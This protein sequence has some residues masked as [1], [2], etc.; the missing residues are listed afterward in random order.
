MK[1]FERYIF[2]NLLIAAVFVS[3]TLIVVVFLSQSMQFLEMVL[4]SN[5]SSGSFWLLTFLA[6]PRFFEIIVPLAM[7]AATIFIY[8]RMTMDSELAAIRS[9]GYSPMDLARP[10]LILAMIVTVF[11]WAMTMWIAPKSLSNMYHMRQV[12]KSQFSALLFR[13]GVFNQV[14]DGLTV[15]IRE[16]TASGELLGV[17]IYDGR[18]KKNGERPS[19]I[20]AKRGQLVGGDD[21]SEQVVVYDGSRQE[22]DAATKK[23]QRLNFERY[24]VD[25]PGNQP[26]RE[27][28]REPDERTITELLMPDNANTRDVDNRNE[29]RVEI[30]RRIVS[31]LLALAF[32]MMSCAG[33]L[34]GPTDRR[35]QGW[36]ITGC[37]ATAS[38]L[39]GLFLAAFSFSRQS[40]W[41]LLLMYLLAFS[42]VVISYA[43]LTGRLEKLRGKFPKFFRRFT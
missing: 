1:I 32:T 29:F 26:L 19:A 11:L 21:G 30:H 42:P 25:L 24:T 9:A 39:Q 3:I 41:G 12:I 23:L 40:D 10:A 16:R 14:D 4:D 31:P 8:N 34:L 33:L 7:M 2:R 43:L 15:Y 6:L 28:W 27:R 35:G 20:L 36:K 13:D 18:Q 22:Y 37:I 38:V 5:A 17:M